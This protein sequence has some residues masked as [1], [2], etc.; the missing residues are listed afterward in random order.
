MKYYTKKTFKLLT[1]K[2]LDTAW[3]LAKSKIVSCLTNKYDNSMLLIEKKNRLWFYSK[4][5]HDRLD[6]INPGILYL[7]YLMLISFKLLESNW[8]S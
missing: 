3:R 2:C 5:A 6:I 8:W 1:R 4:K 7:D